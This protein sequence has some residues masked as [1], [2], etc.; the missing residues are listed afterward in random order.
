MSDF[1]QKPMDKTSYSGPEG[2]FG[3]AF[4]AAENK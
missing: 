4:A 3:S 2:Q 1:L